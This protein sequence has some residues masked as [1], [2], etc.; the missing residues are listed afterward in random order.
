[1]SGPDTQS[2]T[3]GRGSIEDEG[4]S[5]DVEDEQRSMGMVDR[6]VGDGDELYLKLDVCGR[7]GGRCIV[8]WEVWGCSCAAGVSV[9]GVFGREMRRRPPVRKADVDMTADGWGGDRDVECAGREDFVIEGA[10][11]VEVDGT[12]RCGDA[13]DADNV[14]WCA[15]ND[16]DDGF[17]TVRVD[18]FGAAMLMGVGCESRVLFSCAA[19]VVLCLFLCVGVK[20]IVCQRRIRR[21]KLVHC[22][23]GSV[24]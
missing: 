24:V 13:W 23:L 22:A 9:W 12:L 1:M 7:G 11:V 4:F 16:E 14:E 20:A 18:D 6:G 3:A 10:A 8:D 19:I 21:R 15:V 5:G 17:S 2:L